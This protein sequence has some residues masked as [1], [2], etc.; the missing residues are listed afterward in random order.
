MA[1]DTATLELE[2]VHEQ[3]RRL[4]AER[5]GR[6]P[7]GPDDQAPADELHVG[8]D[9]ATR[10]AEIV[11][12]VLAAAEHRRETGADEAVPVAAEGTAAA[13]AR[14]IVEEVLS[15]ATEASDTQTVTTDPAAD[16]DWEPREVRADIV[17]LT[18]SQPLVLV[19]GEA[20]DPEPGAFDPSTLPRPLP[21]LVDHVLRT[22][23]VEEQAAPD[24]LTTPT[25]VRE[26]IR[27]AGE[28]SNTHGVRWL[29]AGAIWML[30]FGLVGP[31]AYKAL[32]S[33]ADMT[34]DLWNG[35]DN[36]VVEQQ[37]EVPEDELPP[38][39]APGEPEPAEAQLD[40]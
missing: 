19:P 1:S 29:V 18:A 2:R 40:G 12:E 16:D 33:S 10:A 14:R 9:P 24:E 30:A 15:A 17:L 20:Y 3:R 28:S 32:I 36:T 4:E 39:T 8:T 22:V 37:V 6:A 13:R 11:Q 26:A 7:L 21:S 31:L 5:D 38:E 23:E 34:I 25:S 27:G 35:T